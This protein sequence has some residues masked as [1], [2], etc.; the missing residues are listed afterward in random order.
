[1]KKLYAYILII[2]AI[3]A[4]LELFYR[5][6]YEEISVLSDKQ[7]VKNAI[8]KK[9]GKQDL[10]LFGSSRSND[11]FNRRI[12]KKELLKLNPNLDK[13]FKAFNAASVRMSYEKYLYSLEKAFKIDASKFYVIE[14]SEGLFHRQG[15]EPPD[16][17]WSKPAKATDENVYYTEPEPNLDE[18]TPAPMVSLEISEAEESSFTNKIEKGLQNFF[19]NNFAL[20][21]LRSTLKFKT[22][23]RL[24]LVKAGPYIFSERWFRSG[25]LKTFYEKEDFS[26]RPK[27]FT[28]YAPTIYSS[29]SEAS[30]YVNPEHKDFQIKLVELLESSK[31]NFIF[32]NLPVKKEKRDEECNEKNQ[33]FY[34]YIS[35]KLKTHVVDFSCMELPESYFDDE[36][37]L[38]EKGR[39]FFSKL[40]AFHLTQLELLADAL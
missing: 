34:A 27:D 9:K 38:N 19:Y 12:F 37:H 13:K 21:R 16:D 33:K 6:N 7:L 8:L 29:K 4:G 20:V 17:D 1:M 22:V 40:L 18:H 25:V 2:I 39:S 15:F 35:S 36:I 26:F 28:K 30:K 11:A 5:L 14:L 32:I 24:L 31:Q 23:A 3:F 10:V